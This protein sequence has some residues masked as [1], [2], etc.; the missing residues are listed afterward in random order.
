MFDYFKRC[1]EEIKKKDQ[2]I[3]EKL[4]KLNDQ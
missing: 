1:S 4:K 2:N 3:Q